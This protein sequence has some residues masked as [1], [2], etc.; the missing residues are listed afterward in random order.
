M[1]YNDKNH[2]IFQHLAWCS[3]QNSNI[4]IALDHLQKAE[5][6]EKDNAD[7][8]YIKGRC[9]L[10]INSI[11]EAH[12]NFSKAIEKTPSDATYLISFAAV[13]YLQNQYHEAFTTILK[14]QNIKPDSC[15][16]WYNLGILY[17]KCK[18]A[19]EAIVAYNRILEIDP[20][21]KE[22]KL[23]VAQFNRQD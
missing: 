9:Y 2:K 13:L 1:S 5:K 16:V 3:F 14:A 15:E 8:F 11:S 4:P 22:A 21:H 17:E 12:E 10:A 19:S 20:N 6:R 18:Q 7:T 23:K